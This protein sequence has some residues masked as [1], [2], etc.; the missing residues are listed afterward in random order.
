MV[1]LLKRLLRIEKPHY[2]LSAR[3]LM[4]LVHEV[5]LILRHSYPREKCGQF[6]TE[7]KI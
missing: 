5:Q 7:D 1:N 3:G 4:R 2:F 6:Q